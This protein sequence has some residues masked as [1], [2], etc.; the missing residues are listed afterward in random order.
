MFKKLGVLLL[1]L[2]ALLIIPMAANADEMIDSGIC[3]KEGD[4]LT[5][6]LDVEGTLI[7]SGT[8]EMANYFPQ[9]QPWDIKNI[10]KIVICDGVTSVGDCAF[11]DCMVTDVKFADSV[12]SIGGLA[13]SGCRNLNSITIPEGV[14]YIGGSA[15]VGCGRLYIMVEENNPNYCDIDGVLFSKDGSEIIAYAKDRLQPKYT[16]PNTVISIASCAFCQCFG[17]NDIEISNNVINIGISAFFGCKNLQN[18]NIPDSVIQIDEMAFGYCGKLNISVADNNSVYCDIDGVLFSKDKSKIIAYSK[19]ELQSEYSIPGF[20][21]K[22]SVS[23]FAS[24]YGLTYI[25]ISNNVTN[26]DERAFSYCENMKKI[27][28]PDSVIKIG[29]DAFES[30]IN[31]TDVYYRGS[32][33]GWNNISIDGFNEY[34]TNA[35]IHF[36]YNMSVSEVLIENDVIIVNTNLDN[37]VVS[38]DRKFSEVF[39]ALYDENGAVIDFYNAVYDGAEISGTLK[40]SD[41]ADHIKVFVWNKD[42]SLE[43]ITDVPEYISL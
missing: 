8:G 22:I 18:I 40:N 17:L 28:I 2:S 23:A 39:V 16:V 41:S 34:L 6:K 9:S 4:N 31:L 35:N 37:L 24:C 3:G 36:N 33:E 21:E 32:E 20:V 42:G 5:W 1:V 29:T 12:T 11:K 25:N 38:E 14:I 27:N 15:F 7:I 10:E 26:I 13:F 30:C 19:D 43:P